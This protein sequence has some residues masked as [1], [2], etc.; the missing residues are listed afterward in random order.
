MHQTHEAEI[1]A[2]EERHD[3]EEG[4]EGMGNGPAAP[5]GPEGARM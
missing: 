2:M 1:K 5:E 3:A 4:G